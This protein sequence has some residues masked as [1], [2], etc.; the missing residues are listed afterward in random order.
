MEN[1]DLAIAAQRSGNE[2]EALNLYRI[3]FNF[4]RQAAQALSAKLDAEPTRSIL[5]RSAATLALDSGQYREAE[6]LICDALRGMPPEGIGDELRDLLEQVHFRRHLGLRGVTLSETEV[7]MSIAGKSVGFGIAPVGTFVPRINDAE[8]LL[9]RTAERLSSLPFR[10]S[11]RIPAAILGSVELFSTVPRAA[12]FAVSFRVGHS[13]QMTFEGVG[14]LGEET[15]DDLLVCLEM[16]NNGNEAELKRKIPDEGYYTNFVALA[17]NIGPD[18]DDVNLVGFTAIRGGKTKTVSLTGGTANA[19]AFAPNLKK[20]ALQVTARADRDAQL[21]GFL[22]EADARDSKRGKIHVVDAEG[23]SHTVVVPIGM[24]TDI[25][26]PLW[27]LEVEIAGTR[28]RNVIHLATIRPVKA[29]T[30]A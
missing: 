13:A 18:G 29:S 9:Y 20:A 30:R 24:M 8:R 16:F 3:A 22:K 25:V 5:H 10:T 4:E 21:R 17:R 28:K 14:S 11:G 26:K 19:V 27:E 23:T 7:Q 6:I 1:A 15:I 12:S 2:E